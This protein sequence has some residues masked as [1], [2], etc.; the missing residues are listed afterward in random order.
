V[1]RAFFRIKIDTL[2]NIQVLI[3]NMNSDVCKG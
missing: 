3:E 1:V 2:G